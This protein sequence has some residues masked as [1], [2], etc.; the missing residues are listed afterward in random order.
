MINIRRLTLSVLSLIACISLGISSNANAGTFHFGT[1]QSIKK[2]E[3]VDLKGPKGEQL[4]LGHLVETH[5]FIL[6]THLND[7]GYVLGI[8]GDRDSYLEMP[9]QEKLSIARSEKLLPMSLPPYK[10]AVFDYLIGYSLWIFIIVIG[11]WTKI[12]SKRKAKA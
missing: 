12:S 1:K 8:V 11:I 6:G 7:K 2:I 3:D 4:Y 9:S 5:F 10:I